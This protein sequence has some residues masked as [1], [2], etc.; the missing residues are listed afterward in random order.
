MKY[1]PECFRLPNKP[2]YKH[3]VIEYDRSGNC[4]QLTICV[5][6]DK[7]GNRKEQVLQVVHLGK[8]QT[9]L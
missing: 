3:G 6:S 9:N 8:V 1:Q 7:K 2:K 4:F 5:F